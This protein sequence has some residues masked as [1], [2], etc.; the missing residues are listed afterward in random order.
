MKTEKSN[1]IKSAE[2][3]FAQR[4]VKT[5]S[6]DDIALHCGI[7]KRTIYQFFE[8]KEALVLAIVKAQ[9]ARNEQYIRM[10]RGISPDAVTELNNF[11]TYIQNALDT[12]TPVFFYGIRKYYADAC[13]IL[14]A[15]RSGVLLP[16][17]R[18]NMTRGIEENVYRNDLNKEV[19]CKLYLWQLENIIEKA[20]IPGEEMRL[21][22]GNLN[23]LFLH[24]IVNVRG[25]KLI[26]VK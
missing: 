15:F 17:I 6:M 13:N 25:L 26:L 23:D 7:S 24:A 14:V 18:Q 22:V 4:G 5:T 11:F 10:C 20:P 16:Y 9:V 2:F 19:A 12:M 21:I 3:I 1:I 8:N